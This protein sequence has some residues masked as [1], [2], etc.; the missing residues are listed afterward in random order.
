MAR[1]A[2]SEGQV[3]TG[4][5]MVKEVQDCLTHFH[6]KTEVLDRKA[7]GIL[8][9]LTARE[10]AAEAQ[11]VTASE[12]MQHETSIHLLKSGIIRTL[13]HLA[14]ETAF[15]RKKLWS[16]GARSWLPIY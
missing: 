14:Y 5:T 16:A 2:S 10:T 7:E 3:F 11:M 1:T 9:G 12:G 8:D 4:E 15:A 6:E 13:V